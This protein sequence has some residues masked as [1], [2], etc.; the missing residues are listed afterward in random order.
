MKAQLEFHLCNALCH[1]QL[2]VGL[3]QTHLRSSIPEK[4]MMLKS[5]N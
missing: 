1:K 4:G 3:V 5:A 2:A